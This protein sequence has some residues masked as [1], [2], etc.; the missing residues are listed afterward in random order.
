MSDQFGSGIDVGAWVVSWP[1]G[2]GG[3]GC[4]KSDIPVAVQVVEA[5]TSTSYATEKAHALLALGLRQ[6]GPSSGPSHQQQIQ[7]VTLQP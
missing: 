6:S 4:A 2:G 1:D 5:T 3:P 7:S